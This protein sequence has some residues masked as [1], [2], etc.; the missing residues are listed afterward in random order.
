MWAAYPQN[1][2]L[3]SQCNRF[4]RMAVS[5]GQSSISANCFK[6]MHK[7]IILLVSHLQI[8]SPRRPP[9]IFPGVQVTSLSLCSPSSFLPS[10]ASLYSGHLTLQCTQDCLEGLFK[11]HWAS[12]HS[13]SFRRTETDYE[14]LFHFL[15]CFLF[16]WFWDMV[17]SS[18]CCLQI[19]KADLEFIFLQVKYLDYRHTLHYLAK[20]Y[21]PIK[22]QG[23]SHSSLENTY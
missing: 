11:H 8:L 21:F 10:P 18:S 17:L 23:D 2:T 1:S 16:L 3:A 4:Y 14:S 19:V 7:L 15:F 5:S 6:I 22:C 12:S 20:I 9:I 13:F